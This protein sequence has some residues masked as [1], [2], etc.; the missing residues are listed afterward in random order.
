MAV[1]VNC[2]QHGQHRFSMCVGTGTALPVFPSF[3]AAS[4]VGFVS[5]GICLAKGL[6]TIWLK[7]GVLAPTCSQATRAYM[8]MDN[9]PEH[10]KRRHLSS[11]TTDN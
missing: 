8:H 2:N 5:Q 7:L 11:P 6:P 1:Q 4:V 9:T 3:Q 10:H